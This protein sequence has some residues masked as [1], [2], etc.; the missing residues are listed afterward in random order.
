MG[1]YDCH[2]V[3]RAFKNRIE[4]SRILISFQTTQVKLS[5]MYVIKTTIKR[6]RE[7]GRSGTR[8]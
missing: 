5:I 4:S 7:A 2:M 1:D 3:Q 8:L 6:D